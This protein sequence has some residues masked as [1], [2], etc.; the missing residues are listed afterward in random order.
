MLSPFLLVGVGGS[1][2]KTVRATKQALSYLLE[3]AGWTNGWPA[4]WQFLHI[5]SPVAQ[6]GLAFPAPLLPAKE[7]MALVPTG[8]SYG[9]VHNNVMKGLGSAE[10][11]IDRALPAPKDVQVPIIM[12]AGAY[13]AVGRTIALGGLKAIEERVS[14]MMTDM[15]VQTAT[16]ELQELTQALGG[17][18]GKVGAPTVVLI[19]S[20]AGGSGAG[21]FIDVA[22]AIKSAIGPKPEA[23]L[24][25]SLLYAP[26]VFEQLGPASMAA[27]V[28]NSMATMAELVSGFWNQVPTAATSQ[29]YSSKGLVIPQDAA[30]SKIGPAFNY[31]I[32]RKNGTVDFGSQD[33]VYLAM[34]NSLAG[35]MTNSTAQSELVAYGMANFGAKAAPRPDATPLV[36]GATPKPL[37]AMG[38]ARVTLGTEKFFEYS[39]ERLAKET[40]KTVL[41]KHTHTD[42][43]LKEKTDAQWVQHFTDLNEGAFISDSRMD[44]LTEQNNQVIEAIHPDTS[45]ILTRLR[46]HVDQA[47]RQGLT[48]AGH[49]FNTWVTRITN[50]YE[51][52]SPSLLDDAATL[53]NARVRAWVETMPD[54]IIGLINATIA[55]QGLP[56]TIGLLQRLI[57]QSNRAAEE[58]LTERASHLTDAGN[59]THLVSQALGPAASMN[60]IPATHPAI[61]QAT[62]QTEMAFY[63]QAMAETKKVAS[64]IIK[65]FS[66]NFI[67]PLLKVLSGGLSTL[68]NNV[69][70]PKLPDSRENPYQSW[71]DFESVS[72]GREFFPAPNEQ[73]LIKP[74]AF[75]QQF[76]TLL[77]ETVANSNVSAPRAAIEEFLL[78]SKAKAV[79]KLKDKMKW[80]FLIQTGL[81]IPMNRQYQLHQAAN[82]PARFDMVTDH[83]KYVEHA[84]KWLRVDGRAFRSFFDQ[85]IVSFLDAEGNNQVRSERGEVFTAA[86]S[87]AV[88]CSDPLVEMDPTLVGAIHGNVPITHLCT[89]IPVDKSSDLYTALENILINHGI[90][91]PDP[92]FIGKGK[93][94]NTKSIEIFTQLEGSVNPMTMSS[95]M[96][97][98]GVEWNRHGM[99]KKS[100]ESFMNARRARPLPEAI[101]AHPSQWRAMMRG[102]F[103]SDL[104]NQLKEVPAPAGSKERGPS[105]SIWA[106]PAN[107][108]IDFPQPLHAKEPVTNSDEYLAVALN[109]L[110]LGMVES[111]QIGSLAPLEPYQRLVEVGDTWSQLDKWI[112]DGELEEGARDPLAESAGTAEM[113]MDDRKKAC[114]SFFIA[115]QQ[116]FRDG[117]KQL[118]EYQSSR[119]YPLWWE[120]R[121]EIDAELQAC[122]E[123]VESRRAQTGFGRKR[124]VPGLAD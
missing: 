62:H 97:P 11:E 64:E 51:N 122:I 23:H 40:L 71:P 115:E 91:N 103:I 120:I 55:Q 6:D 17:K 56:V 15:Q 100:R 113:Q 43:G 45:E 10:A 99:T 5:D 47:V 90:S 69:T 19:S 110:V 46:G 39:A 58:L 59:L 88:G 1:G 83:M 34:A 18:V 25:F 79:A 14:T 8:V 93:G 57:D 78:G 96:A 95:L 21:M 77:T 94:A 82:Q 102:W 60:A 68:R 92:W 80:D 24:L 53:R 86:V 123:R 44:E 109:S 72:V 27:M 52:V 54:H 98:M 65:D 116:Y 9:T 105:V 13:R 87:A 35:W 50:S 121:E 61:A 12:G 4:G 31:I 29:L 73:M 28:P 106:G 85:T 41:F 104:L 3:Q 49:D 111:C 89:G 76:D 33:G 117:L 48:K 114:E 108:W 16:S 84:K 81:W 7:Y 38:F 32:G 26:D 42:A 36:P 37:S 22:E 107:Q 118:K 2:G 101:P 75:P 124:N 67:T 30:Q 74:D 63:Y 70:N 66:A 20:V 112:L 119:V